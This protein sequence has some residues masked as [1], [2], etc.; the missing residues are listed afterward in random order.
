MY[1]TGL[2]S[3]MKEKLSLT[4]LRILPKRKEVSVKNPLC[5]LHAH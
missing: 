4:L 3:A 1:M 5:A 2:R